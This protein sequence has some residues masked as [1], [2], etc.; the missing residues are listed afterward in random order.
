MKL[1]GQVWEREFVR[2]VFIG[3]VNTGIGQLSYWLLLPLLPYQLAFSI[4]YILGIL[5][6]YVLNARIVFRQPLSWKKLL[7][8]PVVYIVQYLCG[9][10]FLHFAV[11]VF[12]V[13]EQIA[14]LMWIALSVPLTFVISRF[15]LRPKGTAVDAVVAD[16]LS[17]TQLQP[18]AQS[19]P[20]PLST[21]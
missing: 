12:Q 8:F 20:Q 18:Q 2:Y 16:A 14:P 1:V 17:S 21:P 19:L 5:L 4:T 6:S 15:I 11:E 9:L 13:S 3:G 7:Q 10:I